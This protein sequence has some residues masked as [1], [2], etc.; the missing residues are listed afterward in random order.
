ME[1]NMSNISKILVNDDLFLKKIDDHVQNIMKD[2]KIDMKDIPEIMMLVT[3]CYNN[4]NNI[5]VTY[6]ELPSLFE[7]I[8]DFILDKYNLVNQ[9]NEEELK[10]MIGVAIKLIM[11]KP[12]IKK[13]C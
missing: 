5:K 11:L 9:D 13:K 1:E 12:T 8:I 7:E 3:E 10:S 4:L 2:D 6:E